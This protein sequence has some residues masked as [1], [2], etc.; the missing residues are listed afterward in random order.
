MGDDAAGGC[1][2]SFRKG[3][4]SGL[5]NLAYRFPVKQNGNE[6][7]RLMSPDTRAPEYKEADQA[8][9]ETA[10]LPA[11]RARQGVTGHNVRYMLVFGLG[12]VILAFLIV[13][14]IFFG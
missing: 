12:G 13:Y 4:I 8:V 6:L 11:R 1:V 9:P 7:E 5:W 3:P 2:I 14:P 10:M